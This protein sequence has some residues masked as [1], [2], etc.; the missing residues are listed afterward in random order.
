MGLIEIAA[1]VDRTAKV[2]SAPEPPQPPGRVV[3]ECGGSWAIPLEFAGNL[4]S[5]MLLDKSFV[6]STAQKDARDINLDRVKNHALLSELPDAVPRSVRHVS[7]P[8]QK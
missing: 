3:R 1:L 6:Q 8:A 2:A 5:L 7:T 4:I